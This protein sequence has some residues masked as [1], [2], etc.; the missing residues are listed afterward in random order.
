MFNIY[1]KQVAFLVIIMT[2][3]LNILAQNDSSMNRSSSALMNN[4]SDLMMY[5]SKPFTGTKGFRKFSIGI[6]AGAL[7]PNVLGGSDDFSKWK[8]GFGY[9]ANLKYQLTHLF[10][11][12]ASVLRGSLM[13]DNSKKVANGVL[14]TDVQK[15]F[16]TDIEY[17][18]SVNGVFT[19]GNI[20]WL[21]PITKVV[22]YVSLGAGLIN[23]KPQV[24][25]NNGV[26]G[27]PFKSTQ[28][29]LP[30]AAGLKFNLS[31]TLN[32][33]LGYRASFIDGDNLDGTYRVNNHKDRFSYTYLGLEFALG[34]KGKPQLM[35]DNPAYRSQAGLQYQIDSLKNSLRI[36]DTDGDGVIDQLDQCPNTPAGVAVN[37]HGCPL[38]TD[39]DGVP[40]YKDKELIT[41]TYCQPVDADGVGKCPPPACCTDMVKKEENTSS[42]CNLG[43]LPSISFKGN[44]GSLSSDAKAMLATV[45]SK[46]K[47]S[48]TCG[49]TVTGYPAASKASQATCNKRTNAIKTYLIEKEGISADRVN[50]NCEVGGGDANTIDIKTTK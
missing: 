50:V 25:Y 22:P 16:K 10:A 24:T 15:S 3:T 19:F 26:V 47:G 38:D 21:R 9:S 23:F 18:W 37:T 28:I 1:R 39:G 42:V 43:D 2:F 34:G 29:V 7:T 4:T 49:I 44:M 31:S 5:S 35:F 30:L 40:D 13:G 12:E 8:V 6:N 45:A 20:N 46:L 48:A 32:L 27:A 17:A 11:L 41:P 33:D 14:P 36:V